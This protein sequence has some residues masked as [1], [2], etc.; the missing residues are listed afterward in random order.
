MPPTRAQIAARSRRLRGSRRPVASRQTGNASGRIDEARRHSRQPGTGRRPKAPDQH[1]VTSGPWG[2]RIRRR[3]RP[4]HLQSCRTI[5][6]DHGRGKWWVSPLW[7]ACPNR[8][9]AV[10]DGGFGRRSRRGQPL[11]PRSIDGSLGAGRGRP[12]PAPTQVAAIRASIQSAG[13]G[14]A[15]F[16]SLIAAGC[17]RQSSSAA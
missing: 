11:R 8:E 2:E 4:P 6:A 3:Q 12:G 17:S 16:T 14:R 15:S 5:A 10:R 9:N 1:A 13:E 7:A